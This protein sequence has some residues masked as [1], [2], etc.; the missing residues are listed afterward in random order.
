VGAHVGRTGA[1]TEAMM[2]VAQ[3]LVNFLTVSRRFIV[4]KRSP[5]GSSLPARGG[6]PDLSRSGIAQVELD[7]EAHV[8]DACRVQRRTASGKTTA[9]RLKTLYLYIQGAHGPAAADAFLLST[10]LDRDYLQDET[11]LVP[12]ELWHSA[13]VAFASRWGRD[14]L[15]QVHRAVV[16][17]E[18]LGVWTHV[19]RGASDV[20]AA[21]RRLDQFGGENAWTER[22]KTLEAEPSL[23]RGTIRLGADAGPQADGLC[24]LARSAELA[25]LPLMFGAAEAR[26]EIRFDDTVA[27]A[28]RVQE[29]EV[30]WREPS[31]GRPFV[32]GGVLGAATVSAVIA[33]AQSGPSLLLAGGFGLAGGAALGA[34]AG[35]EW[36]RRAQTVAQM[37]RIQ[38]LERAATLREARERGAVGFHDGLVVGGQYRLTEKLGVGA[39]GTIWEAERLSD[40][41][42]VAIKLLRAAVAHDSVAADRLRREAAALG[43]AWHPNVVEVY[44]EGHL[45]DGTS[46]LV[47][48][49]LHGES[50]ALRLKRRGAL[51]A[52][53]VLPI[54][55][56]ICDALGAV[57]AAGIVHRDVK[58]SNIF[59]AVD[60]PGTAGEKGGE[61]AKILDFGVARVEWAETRLTNADVPLGTP[62]YMPPEQEQGLEVDARSD[63]F[64]LGAALYEC[65]TG[66][67]P[68]THSRE[69]W[70]P[71]ASSSQAG[72]SGIQPALRAIPPEW[73]AILSRA[74]APLPRDRFPDTR[75]FRE[76]LLATAEGQRL[77]A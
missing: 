57:H 28:G 70:D 23:W 42:P 3:F 4:A 21:Y 74:M 15:R 27:G 76:A 24:A 8:R 44:D 13:L 9:S 11:R 67:P 43:L 50:L 65:L 34:A 55:L 12:V 2:V 31:F 53:D 7:L 36:R 58:P 62:G 48:E 6:S 61:H 5:S 77:S 56:E 68:P 32:L 72:E 73:K 64:A 52:S 71:P 59:L 17:P 10:R 47:M 25:A 22:W 60:P 19:L 37:T 30:R 75:A 18:N 51:E 46:Y 45:P 40:G 41:Q 69:L 35:H 38:A 1:P 33:A 49:R 63:V 29:F 66:L 14:T 54:A 20:L 26:V 16:H 39:N